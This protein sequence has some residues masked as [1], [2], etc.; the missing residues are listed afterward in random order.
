MTDTGCPPLAPRAPHQPCSTRDLFGDRSVDL[1]LGRP[2]D[3]PFLL[4]PLAVG[5]EVRGLAVEVARGVVLE[6]L[7]NGEEV[8]VLHRPV[9][10]IHQAGRSRCGVRSGT[11]AKGRPANDTRGEAMPQS[12]ATAPPKSLPRPGFDDHR[13]RCLR[14]SPTGLTGSAVSLA[15]AVPV[16]IL[17]AC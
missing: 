9:V 10:A 3:Q 14:R 1:Y 13:C 5:R 12:A 8:R 15:R 4:A 7:V 17:S 6:L 16:Q 2:R 11:R